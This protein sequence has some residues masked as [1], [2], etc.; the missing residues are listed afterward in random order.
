M[1]KRR[2]EIATITQTNSML[3]AG[4]ALLLVSCLPAPAADAQGL[5]KL[6]GNGSNS[7]GKYLSQIAE[8]HRV[9]ED[10]YVSW[11]AGYATAL[12]D[13]MAGTHDVLRGTDLDGSI[14]WIN[15]YCSEHPT[16]LFYTAA[17]KL[18]EFLRGEF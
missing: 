4:G 2:L 3:F 9:A 11:L 17:K 15:K 1:V 10:A 13:D 14:A 8:Y 6:W 7:C 18:T 5:M 16:E 12:N